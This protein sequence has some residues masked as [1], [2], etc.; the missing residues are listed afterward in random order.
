MA[1]IIVN[2]LDDMSL[3][4]LKARAAANGRSLADEVCAILHKAVAP[5]SNEPKP[6]SSFIGSVASRRSQEEIDAFV[7]DL[8]DE[9]EK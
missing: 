9:W 6:L 5:V 2:G 8:R 7:R 1:R 4:R 3:G